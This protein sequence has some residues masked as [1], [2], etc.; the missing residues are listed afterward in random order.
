M[1]AIIWSSPRNP[2]RGVA[3][4]LGISRDQLRKAIHRNK[5]DAKLGARDRVT[6]WD[7]G[8]IVDDEGNI[9]GNVYDDG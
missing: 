5:E 9:I 4:R 1:A 3:T 8:A 2:P 6:I 7:D